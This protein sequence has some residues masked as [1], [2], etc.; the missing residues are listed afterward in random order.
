MAVLEKKMGITLFNHDI[1][2]NIAGGVR[3][4]EP[5][6]DLGVITAIVSSRLD[7]PVP[8][9]C[10][11]CGEVGITGEVRTVGQL[12]PRIKEASRLGFSTCIVPKNNLKNNPSVAGI[13]LKGVA[14]IKEAVDCLFKR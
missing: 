4:N 6:V 7:Q 2:L 8:F 10:A 3:L 12:L 14:T 1:F 9:D 11:V 5:G 13:K